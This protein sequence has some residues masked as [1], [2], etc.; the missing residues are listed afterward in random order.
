MGSYISVGMVTGKCEPSEFLESCKRALNKFG[1]NIK[2]I[3]LK[4]PLDSECIR[5]EEKA[6]FIKEIDSALSECYSN[7]LCELHIDYLIEK[8][9]VSGVLFRLK[10]VD[11][12]QGALFEIPEENFD[13]ANEI[14][15]L[16]SKIKTIIK[17]IL[18]YGF[19]Y[20][21]CDNEADIEYS[22][23]QILSMD[24]VYSVMLINNELNFRLAPWK[25][26]GL[27]ERSNA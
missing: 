19:E 12:Y 27:T 14:D 9:C 3:S 11:G 7:D 16:E 5:W 21:F 24:S 10:K 6:V 17:N 25:I 8:R 18:P 26:D 13:V 1:A 2:R 4:Y 15:I 22:K 20:G 23:E